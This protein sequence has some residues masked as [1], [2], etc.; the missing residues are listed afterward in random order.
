[1]SIIQRH[2]IL[3]LQELV[4]YEK[5]LKGNPFDVSDVDLLDSDYRNSLEEMVELAYYF[6]GDEVVEDFINVNKE[7]FQGLAKFIFKINLSKH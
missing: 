5:I 1:M 6:Y 4:D 2:C 3:S 7:T